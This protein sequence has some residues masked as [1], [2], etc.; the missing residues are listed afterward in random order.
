MDVWHYAAII[1]LNFW[2]STLLIC[3]NTWSIV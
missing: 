1:P 3:A 2:T